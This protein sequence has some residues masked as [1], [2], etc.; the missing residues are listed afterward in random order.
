ME[1]EARF[2]LACAALLVLGLALGL[3]GDAGWQEVGWA[4]MALGGSGLAGWLWRV[5]KVWQDAQAQQEARKRRAALRAARRERAIQERARRRTQRAAKAQAAKRQAEA[6]SHQQQAQRLRAAQE[7][8]RRSRQE[9][10]IAAEVARLRA[11]PDAG[12]VEELAA[13]F[14]QRGLRAQPSDPEAPFDLC[15]RDATGA[16]V[17]VARCVPSER[18]AGVVDVRAVEAWRQDAGAQL[19]YLVARAGFAP[20]AVAL[21]RDMPI[22]LVEAYLLAHWRRSPEKDAVE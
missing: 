10:E 6:R 19:A 22:T 21:V 7:A 17:A 9:Q 13:T 5:W 20:A 8:A 18:V 1:P 14:A 2:A 3:G 11:L 15:L 16:L 4:G 12:L